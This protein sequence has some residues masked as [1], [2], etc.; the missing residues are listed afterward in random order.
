MT[1]VLRSASDTFAVFEQALSLFED[2][3]AA[4]TE[5]MSS[6]ARG[7]GSKRPLEMLRTR[8]ESN[9]VLDLIG[10]LQRGILM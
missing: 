5:S 3:V 4:A 8:V 6:P 10:R 1:T 9:A 2:N 7:L